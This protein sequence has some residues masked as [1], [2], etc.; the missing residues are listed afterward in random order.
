MLETVISQV[1]EACLWYARAMIKIT[2]GVGGL[3][4]QSN[5]D[6]YTQIMHQLYRLLDIVSHEEHF[7]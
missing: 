3:I 1:T 2:T 7:R 4:L 5:S 6:C